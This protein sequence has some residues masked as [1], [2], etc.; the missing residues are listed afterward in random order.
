MELISFDLITDDLNTLM[1]TADDC[2]DCGSCGGCTEVGCG[3]CG[4]CIDDI[5]F[6][7]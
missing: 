3:G 7:K 4:G 1:A 2:G 5:P 6:L